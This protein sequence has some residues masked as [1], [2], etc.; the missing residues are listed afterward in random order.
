MHGIFVLGGLDGPSGR[1]IVMVGG[2]PYAISGDL[3]SLD[4]GSLGIGAG[5]MRGFGGER[6]V[7][8][9]ARGEW[10]IRS[11]MKIE[12]ISRLL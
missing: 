2:T 9:K 4:V 11:I 8:K 10:E 7:V 6:P 12:G 3:R 5:G 1:A